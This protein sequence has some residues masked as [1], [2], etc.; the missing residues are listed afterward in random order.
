[1]KMQ[2]T[3]HEKSE[4]IVA[5]KIA[6]EVILVPIRQKIGDLQNIYTLNEVAAK[7]WELLDG[8][9]TLLQIRDVIISEFE[10][11]PEQAQ[12]DLEEFLQK[13]ENIEAIKEV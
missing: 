5:R 6:E 7:I 3:R 13:L 12:K 1:M 11:N 2:E 4:D 9:K 8:Q 10:I